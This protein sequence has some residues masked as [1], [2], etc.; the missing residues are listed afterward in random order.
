M[1]NTKKRNIFLTMSALLFSAL[2]AVLLIAP[3]TAKAE[4]PTSSILSY[5]AHNNMTVEGFNSGDTS[6]NLKT[7]YDWATQQDHAVVF[8]LDGGNGENKFT[9]TIIN[10]AVSETKNAL[11]AKVCIMSSGGINDNE[12][13]IDSVSSNAEIST[14]RNLSENHAALLPEIAK[15][16]SLTATITLKANVSSEHAYIKVMPQW[17]STQYDAN[18]IITVSDIIIGDPTEPEPEQPGTTEDPETPDNPGE[19]SNNESDQTSEQSERFDFI[20]WLKNAGSNAAEWIGDNVGI[21]TT[22]STVLIVGAAIIVI[23]IFR[24]RR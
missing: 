21:A 11:N 20:K 22:G 6:I 13:E 14:G 5:T 24:R 19:P 23:L 18:N 12:L 7:K 10:N 17:S 8:E 9:F 2:S 1:T 3:H 4:Q 16:E 15:G